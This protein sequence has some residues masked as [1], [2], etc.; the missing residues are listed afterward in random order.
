MLVPFSPC[1]VI[2][3]RLGRVRRDAQPLIICPAQA[4][5]CR[6]IFLRPLSAASRAPVLHPA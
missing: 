1:E 5:K 2:T 6:S 3:E 4:A